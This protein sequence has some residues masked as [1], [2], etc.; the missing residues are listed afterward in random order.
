MASGVKISDQVTDVYNEMRLV[1]NDSNSMERIRLVVFEIKDDQIQPSKIFREKDVLEK[2]NVYKLFLEQMDSEHCC[3]L[4]YDCHYETK[5]SPKEE[6]VFVMWT[7]DTSTCKEK[8]L[9]ASSKRYIKA[10][11]AGI[12]HELEINDR[13]DAEME[14]FASSLGKNVLGI[15]GN[16]FGSRKK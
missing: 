11:V 13:S 4:L 6:L 5:D 14:D 10:V 8:M 16:T 3:Y 7:P 12:K 2:K 15:E 1:K 9:Y